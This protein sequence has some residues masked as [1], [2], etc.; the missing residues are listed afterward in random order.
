MRNGRWAERGWYISSTTNGSQDLTKKKERG[1]IK[2]NEIVDS[3]HKN[4]F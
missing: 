1:E 3:R 2:H 4:P